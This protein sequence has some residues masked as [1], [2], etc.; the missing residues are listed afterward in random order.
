[1]I[2]DLVKDLNNSYLEERALRIKD[3][4]DQYN[5]TEDDAIK[6]VDNYINYD[7]QENIAQIMDRYNCTVTQA[8]DFYDT[9]PNP[10]EWDDVDATADALDIDPLDVTPDDV[11]AFS[12]ISDMGG[13]RGYYPIDSS[14]G[15]GYI[16]YAKSYGWALLLIFADGH[17]ANYPISKEEAM[18]IRYSDSLGTYYNQNMRNDD[19]YSDI[20]GAWGCI[21][22]DPESPKRLMSAE[23]KAKL[24]KALQELV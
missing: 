18:N 22:P 16:Y 15:T 2:A 12:E 9:Y 14:I 6:I 13:S 20:P 1:M 7:D 8:M 21:G 24:P 17:P 10:V 23:D 11:E 3:L 4:T 5:I 19:Q